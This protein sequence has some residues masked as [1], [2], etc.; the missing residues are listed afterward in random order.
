MP[1]RKALETVLEDVVVGLCAD[2]DSL[3]RQTREVDSYALLDLASVALSVVQP[4]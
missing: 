4:L 3:E 2:L 1:R